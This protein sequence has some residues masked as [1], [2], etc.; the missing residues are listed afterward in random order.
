MSLAECCVAVK[1]SQLS[2]SCLWSDILHS[3]NKA[4]R[5]IHNHEIKSMLS[6]IALIGHSKQ[7]C[8]NFT[9]E[10]WRQQN[11]GRPGSS[12]LG[13]NTRPQ[14]NLAQ[15]SLLWHQC[16]N[17]WWSGCTTLSSSLQGV[18]RL[19][20]GAYPLLLQR[21]HSLFCCFP[22]QLFTTMTSF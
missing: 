22:T 10:I 20:H 18:A 6:S 1:A 8:R 2:T 5:N 19:C 11:L 13:P 4:C 12:Q 15:L 17:N 7:L 21:Y 16:G 14:D 9:L 3:V